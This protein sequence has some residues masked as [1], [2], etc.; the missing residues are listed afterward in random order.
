MVGDIRR[1]LLCRDEMHGS[2]SVPLRF[3]TFLSMIG[4]ID[5]EGVLKEKD[6]DD[7]GKD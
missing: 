4:E 6:Y 7:D 2:Q 3:A 1:L 5:E